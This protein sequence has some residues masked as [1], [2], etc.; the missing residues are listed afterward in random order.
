MHRLNSVL[1]LI[2][3][4]TV[5]Y[6]MAQ[7]QPD[8]RLTVKDYLMLLPDEYA[9]VPKDR[10][11][12]I[13][14]YELGTIDVKNGFMSYNDSAESEVTIALF[15]KPDGSHLVAVTYNGEGFDEQKQDI[16]PIFTLNFLSYENG[17]WTD[18]TKDTLP[19]AFDDKL[20]YKL[21]RYGT[22]IEVTDKD[23][24]RKYYLAW[25][26]GKFIVKQMGKTR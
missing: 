8:K 19:V 2:I 14:H 4:V 9:V 15:K 21:P 26:D 23:G 11:E 20:I 5:Q 13:I 10:R 17:K 3:L 24:K 18:V 1:I 22:T 6:S 16:V 7:T 12:Q 25:G